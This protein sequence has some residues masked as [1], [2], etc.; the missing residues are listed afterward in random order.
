MA[1]TGSFLTPYYKDICET[2]LKFRE[3]KHPLI[4]KTVIELIPQLATFHPD[5]FVQCYL[6]T[7]VDKI[8]LK[9]ENLC[10]SSFISLGK[11]ALVVTQ[12]MKPYLERSV[13]ILKFG[14]SKA[15]NGGQF[16]PEVLQSIGMIS[17]SVSSSV[18]H[19]HMPELIGKQHSKIQGCSKD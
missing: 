17:R 3:H 7:C 14:L 19:D 2:A 1:H 12:N 8:L 11:V 18:M 15:F 16:C 6:T 10:P 5:T 4:K 9:K 13:E